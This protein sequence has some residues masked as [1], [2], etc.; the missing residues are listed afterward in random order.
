KEQYEALGRFV[1][2]FEAMVNEIRDCSISLLQTGHVSSALVDI[3]FH[4][5]ALTAMPLFEV[6]RALIIESLGLPG[7]TV[8]PEDKDIFQGVLKTIA[9]EYSKL[10]N[11][12]NT[13]LHGTWYIGYTTNED[14]NSDT[15][16]LRKFKPASSGLA[17][18]E[19]V[20]SRAFDLLALTDRCDDTRNWIAF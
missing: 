6:F 17:K 19:D 10:T 20:P 18:E 14:P 12:R 1:V 16:F 5:R 11:I 2:A 13:L 4:H 8:A 7:T 3:A 15:F 9:S